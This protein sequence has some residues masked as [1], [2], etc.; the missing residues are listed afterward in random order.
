MIRRIPPGLFG[1]VVVSVLLWIPGSVLAG[2]GA[3][4]AQRLPVPGGVFIRGTATGAW[5]EGPPVSVTVRPFR[6]DETEVTVGAFAAWARSLAD[7][8]AAVGVEGPWYR[9][10]AEGAR[11]LLGS[12][13]LSA[14]AAGVV[15]AALTAQLD[16]RSRSDDPLASPALAALVATQAGLPVRGV[17]WNDASRFCAAQRGRLPSEVEWERAARGT[18]GRRWP[19][20]DEWDVERVLA[21]L[22]AM[23]GPAPVGSRPQGASPFGALDMA[24]NVWEWVS[25][26]YEE[27]FGPSAKGTLPAAPADHLRDPRQGR[28]G[29]GRRVIRGGAWAADTAARAR[30]DTR[31]TRRLWSNPA[32]SAADLGFRCADD[33]P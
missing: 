32:S 15:R 27:H 13:G 20:G 22:G 2:G 26:L 23:N 33:G 25:D 21:G 9:W 4:T 1:A 31:T 28:D 24:G 12:G 6:I 16:P 10:S 5:D 7:G 18:D 17:T 19:W 30:F 29:G 3:G 11:D 8:G 14:A